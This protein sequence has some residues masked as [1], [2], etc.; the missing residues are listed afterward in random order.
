M[1]MYGISFGLAPIG[2]FSISPAAE[3][4]ITLYQMGQDVYVP[5]AVPPVIMESGFPSQRAIEYANGADVVIYPPLLKEDAG[6]KF[7]QLRRM[8]RIIKGDSFGPL[9]QALRQAGFKRVILTGSDE[10]EYH[11]S[12]IFTFDENDVEF[13]QRDSGVKIVSL[14][15]CVLIIGA[16]FLSQCDDIDAATIAE[17]ELRHIL[18]ELKNSEFGEA[19][20][21]LRKKHSLFGGVD[22]LIIDSI[23]HFLL[24]L[25]AYET[26]A[27]DFA[28][29]DIDVM[30]QKSAGS[31]GNLDVKFSSYL[32]TFIGALLQ[33][34]YVKRAIGDEDGYQKY[35]EM[36][37]RAVLARMPYFNFDRERCIK[38]GLEF[39]EQIYQVVMRLRSARSTDLSG[40]E[41]LLGKVG[42]SDAVLMSNITRAGL[43][44]HTWEMLRNVT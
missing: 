18:V 40:L 5:P 14:N 12:I 9:R 34:A 24:R 13:L 17:H 2:G 21:V 29:R 16:V 11:A 30:F 25:H 22:S 44:R 3:R 23:T 36:A 32:G 35:A 31:L 8:Q 19:L 39:A 27:A 33:S 20:N 41:D 42:Q 7:E 28:E 1:A 6:I 15:D 26:K 4:R 43:L 10:K 38:E 37:R